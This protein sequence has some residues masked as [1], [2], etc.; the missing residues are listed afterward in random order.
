M[1]FT[2]GYPL[3]RKN[4][5][6]SRDVKNA[7]ALSL[8]PQVNKIDREG[9]YP[10]EFLH[11]LGEIGGFEQS[12]T[13]AFGGNGKGFKS[14]LQVI[15]AVS[16]TC[17]CTGF[18]TWC[19]I[20]CVWYIQKSKNNYLRQKILPQ[21]AT[22]QVLAGTGLSN[23][24]KHF[25]DIEKIALTA[26][27]CEGGYIIDGLLPWVS[28]LGQGHYF[29]IVAKIVDT[30]DYLMAIVSDDFPGLN[31]KSTA[32]FIAL[33]GSQTFSCQ[34]REVFVPDQYILASPCA[35][36]IQ[37]IKAGFVLAQVG[38]GLGVTQA[39]VNA[40]KKSN[41]RYGHVNGFL[42][43]TVEFIEE[44][45]ELLRL[46][47]YALANKLNYQK[48]PDDIDFFKKVVKCRIQ[49]SEL[50]LR[51]SQSAILYAGARGYLQG[52]DLDRR[53]RESYF[54]AIVTPALKHL[55]KILHDFTP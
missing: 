3:E 15:E 16:Q 27:P 13:A 47:S 52:S 48:T 40:M 33:E 50:A 41:V 51:S 11:Q 53:L 44:D 35:D 46:K 23:P 10:R 28:N 4:V 21:I 2:V 43:D 24:M 9:Y 39:S 12:V 6:F 38:M 25:A 18:M 49:A 29:A 54:V 55:K 5:D 7:I 34:F 45:L 8:S 26:K 19:H 20:A 42:D 22:G 17:L 31:L 1:Q 14:A 32:H 30:N 37:E 36:Y